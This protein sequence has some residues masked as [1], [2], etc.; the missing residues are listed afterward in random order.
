M[1]AHYIAFNPLSPPEASRLWDEIVRG[2]K[3]PAATYGPHWEDYP[4][5]RQR[6]WRMIR[7]GVD[8][9]FV[10]LEPAGPYEW[11]TVTALR[12]QAQQQRLRPWFREFYAHQA[13]ADL[14]VKY[15]F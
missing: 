8:L 4:V 9:G 5:P 2:M 10:S 13:F 6:C 1:A 15:R 12:P 14:S 3:D 11:R 7:D